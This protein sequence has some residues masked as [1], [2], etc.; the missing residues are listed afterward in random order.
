MPFISDILYCTDKNPVI[1][2]LYL[3]IWL[4]FLWFGMSCQKINYV[5]ANYVISYIKGLSTSEAEQGGTIVD[6]SCKIL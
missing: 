6:I 4:G 3:K 2:Y 5:N 1:K